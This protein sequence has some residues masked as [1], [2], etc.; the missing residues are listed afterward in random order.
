MT[1][2][3]RLYLF[4]FAGCA[5]IILLLIASFTALIDPLGAYDRIHLVSLEAYRGNYLSSRTAKA[6]LATH[7]QCDV[8]LLG[9]SRVQ[10]GLPVTDPAYATSKVCNLGLNGTALPEL[11]AALD[12]AVAHNDVKR[13]IFS[14][15]FEFFSD[16]RNSGEDFE[17]SRFNPHVN[18]IDYQFRNLIGA[19]A[20]NQAWSL[21]RDARRKKQATPDAA[22]GFIP[23]IIPRK[24]SQRSIFALRIRSFLANPETYGAFHYS[25]QRLQLFREMIRRCRE[26]GI[27]LIVFIP[28]VHA[29]QL[30]TIRVA[31]LWPVFEQWKRDLA[32]LMSSE[33]AA[34][35]LWDFSG[36]SGPRAE[37]VPPNGDK[38]TRMRWFIDSSHFTP[39]LGQ[40]VLKQLL[41]P[42]T[43]AEQT[44][45]EAIGVLSPAKVENDLDQIRRDRE[46]YAAS[47]PDEVEWVAQ[48]KT[49]ASRKIK[50]SKH[51][52]F[53]SDSPT[54][55]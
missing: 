5:G 52:R 45:A 39:A 10:V 53:G 46:T 55:P 2:G 12:F 48:L 44:S 36:Y 24:R 30:E 43:L 23:K 35:P 19:D 9:S 3:H 29:L 32:Q 42:R 51:P 33:D 49:R 54:P 14:A 15:D 16:V 47:H 1:A 6:E 7:R 25:E 22:R 37:K 38:T 13:V 20:I 40:V 34:V 28:P 27:D 41:A 26:R 4:F 18:P 8:I 11:N 31:Q 21:L 17:N 50:A